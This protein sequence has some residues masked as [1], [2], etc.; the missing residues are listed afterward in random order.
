MTVES[1]DLQHMKMSSEIATIKNVKANHIVVVDAWI[2]LIVKSWTSLYK[3]I[4]LYDL[5]G[6]ILPVNVGGVEFRRLGKKRHHWTTWVVGLNPFDDQKRLKRLLEPKPKTEKL[7]S[8]DRCTY[9]LSI[10]LS[11]DGKQQ[12]GED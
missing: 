3:I 12:Q 5:D 6:D 7:K 2:V 8:T 4:L 1:T 10:D 9:V 11:K